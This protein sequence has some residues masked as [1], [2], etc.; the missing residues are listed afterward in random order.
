MLTFQIP[1]SLVQGTLKSI[2]LGLTLDKKLFSGGE[3]D[4][5]GAVGVGFI[6][7]I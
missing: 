5:I 2:V 6:I 7:L 3:E 4:A 1:K